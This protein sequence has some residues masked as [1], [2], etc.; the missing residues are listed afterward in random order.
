MFILLKYLFTINPFVLLLFEI[1]KHSMWF[2]GIV[3]DDIDGTKIEYTIRP[4]HEV[5][6]FDDLDTWDTADVQP[7]FQEPGPRVHPKYITY[8]FYLHDDNV[9]LLIWL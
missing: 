3:F 1:I 2:V 7:R 4:S 5:E 6:G 8:S 9:Q